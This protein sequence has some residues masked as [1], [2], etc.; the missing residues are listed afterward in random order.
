[1]GLQKVQYRAYL[2]LGF[3]LMIG[4]VLIITFVSLNR[5]WD[6]SDQFVSVVTGDN[7]R[8]E[9][10]A[11]MTSMSR[12]RIDHLQAMVVTDDSFLQDEHFIH[13][14]D[15]G[16]EFIRARTKLAAM[17]LS[18]EEQKL[19]DEQWSFSSEA[20]PLQYKVIDLLHAG[21]TQEAGRLLIEKAIP[22]QNKALEVI[23]RFAEMQRIRSRKLMEG[24]LASV[25]QTENM[26]VSL[27]I[28]ISS[29]VILIS[30]FVFRRTCH[31]IDSLESNALELN[32]T[33]AQL[34]DEI[35]QH[36]NTRKE[37]EY[38]A[39][40]D[41]L[42][43]LPNRHLCMEYL[44]RCIA[45]AQRHDFEVAVLFIDLDGFKC[46]NDQHGHDSGDR[47]LKAV[48]ERLQQSVR[49]EDLVA[50]VG[51]DEF[52][53][54][55]G[56]EL[57]IKKRAN[58]VANKVIEAMAKPFLILDNSYLIGASV[59]I[60]IYDSSDKDIETLLRDADDAMYFS[61]KSGRGRY[62]F[63]SDDV[64]SKCCPT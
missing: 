6:L 45:Q 16:Q 26:V 10:A 46:I 31:L 2:V 20:G 5:L 30:I 34:L 56:G 19:L 1:M 47:L 36:E 33:N 27:A 53:I 3:S 32:S 43:G 22:V 17:E 4:L 23:D 35:N 21:L 60:S 38:M 51:G 8:R 64:D 14:R 7:E 9:L 37:L 50:R 59:G 62:K 24:S 25:N 57:E 11:I 48:G 39:G 52:I 55:F 12:Q 40:H 54:V 13:M 28:M 61:K 15:A 44:K 49:E 18:Q 41:H 58:I 42:T 29:L 63:Y